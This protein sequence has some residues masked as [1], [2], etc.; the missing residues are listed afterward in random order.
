MKIKQEYKKALRPAFWV[1]GMFT[2]LSII[3]IG[4]YLY[5]DFKSYS[6]TFLQTQHLELKATQEEI[7]FKEEALK[8]LLDLTV[9]RIAAT[10]GDTKRI[11]N[12]L[13]SVP[14]LVSDEIPVKFQKVTYKKLSQ[15]NQLITRFGI[16]SLKQR[17]NQSKAPHNKIH[18]LAFDE[19]D[20][21]LSGAVL[22]PKGHLEGI[23]EIEIP[24]TSFLYTFNLK[25]TL[26]FFPDKNVILLQKEPIAL[27]GKQP[28]PFW[29]YGLKHWQHYLALFLVWIISLICLGLSTIF[30]FVI[31]RRN[32][33]EQLSILSQQLSKTQDEV[34]NLEENLNDQEQL[35]EV[36]QSA[37]QSYKQFQIQFHNHR[38]EQALSILGILDIVIKDYQ[39]QDVSL[40]TKEFQDIVTS[41]VEIAE[42]LAEGVPTSLRKETIHVKGVLENARALFSERIH[43]SNLNLNINCP[44]TLF[45]EGDRF[46][47]EM[48][49]MNVIGKN[50]FMIPKHG[51][52]EIK[53]N[54]TQDCVQIQIT[55]TGFPIDERSQKQ[56]NQSFD[57][58]LAKDTFQR[59]CAENGFTYNHTRDKRGINITKI[60]LPNMVEEFE[61]SNVVQ[62][63]H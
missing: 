41:S 59:F 57:F 14:S 28:S 24:L 32:F 27:Y 45:Y 1:M 29:E 42:H 15:P 12:I 10:S 55:D 22:G 34:N 44:G 58:F 46:L 47:L 36:H 62:L 20:V 40:S 5:I 48:L 26:S 31:I 51:K 56:I 19:Y 6:S 43:K 35:E 11:Q 39:N 9:K 4:A 63:F 53:V 23:L 60:L 38:R 18:L 8:K 37:N 17:A 54:Q 21:K 61:G 30:L 33:K 2:F 25:D 3:F 52:M 13:T 7:R 50:I 49:L 16:S